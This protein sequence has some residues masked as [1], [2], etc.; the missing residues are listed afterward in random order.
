M[1]MQ[2]QLN[3]KHPFKNVLFLSFIFSLSLLFLI[4]FWILSWMRF[5]R[6]LWMCSALLCPQKI[7]QE[8]EKIFMHSISK[9]QHIPL[10]TYVPGI[11]TS[12]GCSAD[13]RR[14]PSTPDAVASCTSSSV[15]GA[16]T[17]R[18][19]RRLDH[20]SI[21]VSRRRKNASNLQKYIVRRCVLLYLDSVRLLMRAD[22]FTAVICRISPSVDVKLGCCR[23]ELKSLEFLKQFF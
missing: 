6:G 2:L 17:R 15:D 13:G 11:L 9:S 21:L 14:A 4:Y 8:K 16:D 19:V 5:L 1:N 3:T 7:C 10:I 12:I 20:G 23:A 18:R 22:A